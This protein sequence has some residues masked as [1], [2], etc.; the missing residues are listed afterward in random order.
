MD[1]Q[2]GNVIINSHLS[3]IPSGGQNYTFE[4]ELTD[5]PA[6]DIAEGNISISGLTNW[7]AGFAL[8][9]IIKCKLTDRKKNEWKL[10]TY[11]KIIAHWKDLHADYLEKRDS[12]KLLR[13]ETSP[14]G[15]DNNEINRQIER[16]ELKR[17]CISILSYQNVVGFDDINVGANAPVIEIDLARME[18]HSPKVRFFEHAFEWD[19][20]GYVFYPY[21]WTDSGNNHWTDLI[22]LK[23]EDLL[24]ENFLRAG[25]ARVVIPVRKGFEDA[26]NFFLQTGKPWLGGAIPKIGDKTYLP[27]TEEM[28][29]ASGAPGDEKPEGEPWEFRVPTRLIK[30]RKDDELPQWKLDNNPDLPKS[31]G[32]WTWI[33]D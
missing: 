20:I 17:S 29:E 3:A 30:L 18:E 12:L 4:K 27:I 16:I 5:F 2:I 1:L 13:K 15:S 25:Y 11:E 21:F 9:I 33:A 14:L 26:I 19:K 23:S 24:F 28:K 22:F 8:N 7:I 6:A 32:S 10:R 31:T